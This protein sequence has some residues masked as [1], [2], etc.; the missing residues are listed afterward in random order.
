[1]VKRLF[2]PNTELFNFTNL[3]SC[4]LFIVIFLILGAIAF[5]HPLAVQGDAAEYI[6]Q[7]QAIALDYSLAVDTEKRREYWNRTAPYELKLGPTKLKLGK[8]A[9]ALQA[10]G[11]FGGLYPDSHQHFR[12]YHFWGYSLAVAPFYWAIHKIF[13]A[14]P[15]EYEA[16]RIANLF[17]LSSFIFIA[18]RINKNLLTVL[19]CVLS[20]FSPLSTYLSWSHPEIF[21]FS[22]I[23]TAFILAGFNKGP[24]FLAPILLGIAS[25]QNCPSLLW[26]PALFWLSHFKGSKRFSFKQAIPWLL[27][28]IL[29]LSSPLYYLLYFGT[30]SLINSLDLASTNYLSM[31]RCCYL[32][33]GIFSGALWCFPVHFFF[34]PSWAR[35]LGLLKTAFILCTMVA[36]AY[37]T[38]ANPSI[39]SSQVGSSRYLLWASAPLFAL[40]LQAKIN[41]THNNYK[42]KLFFLSGLLLTLITILTF[43]LYF[44]L[45]AEV[46]KFN[47]LTKC[48]RLRLMAAFDLKDDPEVIVEKFFPGAELDRPWKFNKIYQINTGALGTLIII[49]NRV[50]SKVQGLSLIEN[51]EISN[52]S[53]LGRYWTGWIKTPL[54]DSHFVLT[55]DSS[56]C[57]RVSN[58]QSNRYF[59]RPA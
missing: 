5:R 36:V 19:L 55:I 34:L 54:P 27:G 38:T 3:N 58:L 16:F 57:S 6:I 30:W 10:G 41:I 33:V 2:N 11:G 1:M 42:E 43:Q 18:F 31:E 13:G 53:F 4:S 44:L 39:H 48:R 7:T 50:S 45:A 15:A 47:E 17:F 22:L 28:I 24:R 40:T 56:A 32:L 9:E 14:G 23:G 12:Y 49:P 20:L 26:F 29:A 37:L 25:A 59:S 21:Q 35:S 46:I 8:L 52:N 51:L